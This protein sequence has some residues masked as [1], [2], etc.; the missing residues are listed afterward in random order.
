MTPTEASAPVVVKLGGSLLEERRSRE[1]VLSAVARGSR[2]GDAIVLVHGA[3]ATST[4]PWRLG[5]FP[6]E[7][8]RGC[9]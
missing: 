9:A 8:T 3:D 1:A 6:G 5:G 4:R 2:G 7:P